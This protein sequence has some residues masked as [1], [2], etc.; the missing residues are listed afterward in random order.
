MVLAVDGENGMSRANED[1]DEEEG[2]VR[3]FGGPSSDAVAKFT[4]HGELI[5]SACDSQAD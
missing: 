2:H 5:S 1:S 3:N 4:Q